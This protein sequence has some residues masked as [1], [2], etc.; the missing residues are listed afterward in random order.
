MNDLIAEAFF[1]IIS[2]GCCGRDVYGHW[3]GKEKAV[4]ETQQAH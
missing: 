4:N 2:T 1:S 3:E